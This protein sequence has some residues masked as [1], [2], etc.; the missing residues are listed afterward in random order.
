MASLHEQLLHLNAPHLVQTRAITH[1]THTAGE[2]WVSLC[3]LETTL[4]EP[5]AAIQ[6]LQPHCQR[7]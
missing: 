7:R 1:T 5:G 4:A 6:E 2:T 3:L